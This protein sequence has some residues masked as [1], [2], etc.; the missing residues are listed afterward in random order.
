[1]FL[2]CETVQQNSKPII[3]KVLLS[4]VVYT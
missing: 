1:L 4:K 2:I 3:L